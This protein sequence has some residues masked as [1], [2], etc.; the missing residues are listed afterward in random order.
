MSRRLLLACLLAATPLYAAE[1]RVMVTVVDAAGGPITDLK[2][3]HFV[4]TVDKNPRQVTRAEYRQ[5]LV[6]VVLMIDTSAYTS[7][8]RRDIE[9]IAG[10]FISQLS[11]KEQMAIVSYATSADLVQDFTSSKTL[12]QRAVTHLRYGNDASILDSLYATMDGAFQSAAGRRVLLLLSSGA[13]G[14]NR[15]TRKDALDLAQRNGVSIF[16]LSLSGYGGNPLENLAEETAG[17]FLRGKELRFMDRVAKNL[18]DALRGHYELTVSGT[19]D[20]KLKVEVRQRE[21]LKEKLQVC[22]RPLE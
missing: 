8:G 9:R 10:L 21:G 20:G 13:N 11:E 18:F 4:V 3:D 22:Y 12:L 1:P 17:C 6:D 14:P 16:A 15:V 5:D 19:L 7:A 2:P